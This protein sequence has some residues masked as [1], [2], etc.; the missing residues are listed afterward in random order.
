[1]Q[2]TDAST[3][4]CPVGK[5]LEL[6]GEKW[7]LL[8]MRDALNGIRRFDD[9]RRHMGLSEAVLADRLRKLVD[10]GV[11]EPKPYQELGQRER[12]E[13]LVTPRG[14]DLLPV[15]VALKQWGEEHLPD[16]LGPVVEVRHRN[17]GGLVR[18][19]LQCRDHGHA[20]V[21]NYDTFATVGPAAHAARGRGQEQTA[22]RVRTNGSRPT[23]AHPE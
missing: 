17:C 22:H 10:A 15:I 11:L 13:Y 20:P 7:T 3:A 21:S 14:G 2:W 9:F 23:K 5:A 8:I 19:V 16:P 4:N 18:A 1:M 12:N 6:L